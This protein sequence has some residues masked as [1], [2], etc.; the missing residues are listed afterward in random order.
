MPEDQPTRTGPAR[1][2]PADDEFADF[3]L[4]NFRSLTAF[5]LMHGATLT[6]ANDVVQDT[7][8]EAYRAW[9]R[10][11]HHR[12]WAYRVVS[13]TYGRRRFAAAEDLVADPPEPSPPLCGDIEAWEQEHDLLIALAELPLRQRQ[14]MAWTLSGFPSAEIAAELGITAEAVR[15]SRRKARRL[16]STRV[17]REGT[18]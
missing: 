6:E 7:M 3:Y 2:R 16:L 10:I 17:R 13:K 14:V 18:R 11:D 1:T 5:L 9:D 4:G 15:S 8:I 12:A